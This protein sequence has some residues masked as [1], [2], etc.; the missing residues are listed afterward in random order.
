MPRLTKRV[1]DAAEPQ[2]KDIFLWDS[3][4]PAFAIRVKPSGTKSFFVQY[5]NRSGRSRR[6]TLGRFGVL[7]VEQGRAAAKATLAQV[8]LGGDPAESKAADRA[9]VTVAQLCDDYF[10]QAERGLLITRRG[11]RSLL[12]FVQTA[13]ELSATSSPC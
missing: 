2:S 4:L 6:L 11:R 13:D 12:R 10:D 9:A 7:T 1:V 8:A 3:E 5:R